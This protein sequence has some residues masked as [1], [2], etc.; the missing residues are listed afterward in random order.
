MWFFI[1]S[2]GVADGGLRTGGVQTR[3]NGEKAPYIAI[4]ILQCSFMPNMHSQ[5]NILQQLGLWN[6]Q[7]FSLSQ[8]LLSQYLHLMTFELLTLL[9]V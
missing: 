5:C 1:L 9:G 2:W 4:L 3:K 7:L 8:K 6:K